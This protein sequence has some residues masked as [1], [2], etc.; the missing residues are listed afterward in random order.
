MVQSALVEPELTV[1]Q[2][3][4][5]HVGLVQ[6]L[7]EKVNEISASRRRRSTLAGAPKRARQGGVRAR[8]RVRLDAQE[9]A[10]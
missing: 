3:G 2:V 7:L 9:S 4:A 5:M 6:F 10:S 8:G 1:Q